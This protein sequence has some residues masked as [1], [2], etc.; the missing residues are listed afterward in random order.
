MGRTSAL[1]CTAILSFLLLAACGGMPTADPASSPASGFINN[2]QHTTAQLW[3]LWTTAQQNLSQQIDLNPL[4]QQVTGAPPNLVPGDP[5]ALNVSPSH[6]MVASQADV[7][8]SALL[9]ATGMNRP[10]PTGLISCPQ[11]CNVQYAPAY[12]LYAQPTTRYASSWENS[13]NNFDTLV[14]YEFE[15]QIL[16]TLGYD[17]TWR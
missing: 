16:H 4:Q 7:S 3:T 9:A 6:L 10:N 15:N 13:G 11:P 1:S 5:R 14:E 12:S 2:T 17:M 8:S